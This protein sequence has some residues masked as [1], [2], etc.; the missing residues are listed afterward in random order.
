MQNLNCHVQQKSAAGQS[1]TSGAT[2]GREKEDD[3]QRML[4]E[5]FQ[6]SATLP[7]SSRRA[8]DITN[9]IGYF[10][11]K[12]MLPISTTSGIRFKRLLHVLEPR[13]VI[14]H[15]KTFT[16]R[17]LPAMYSSL[18]ENCVRPLVSSA[19]HFALTTDCLTSRVGQA[20]ISVTIHFI[21]ED[22][23]LK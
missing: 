1:L 5:T 18:R 15:R 7:P 14:P 17:T 22:F 10:V 23:Q 4:S 2:H 11:A 16:E 13:Y 8:N 12:D 19:K 6:T 21:T 9:A 3:S 20:F